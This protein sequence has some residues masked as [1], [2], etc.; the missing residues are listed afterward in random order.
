M[1]YAEQHFAAER[2]SG[3]YRHVILPMD[4]V[5]GPIERINDPAWRHPHIGTGM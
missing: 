3:R 4:E 1:N 5:R 2:E